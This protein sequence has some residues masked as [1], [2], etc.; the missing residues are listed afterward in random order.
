[1]IPRIQEE[2]L[3]HAISSSKII[4]VS[5]AY[6]VGKKTLIEKCCD[7]VGLHIHWMNSRLKNNTNS[8]S[9]GSINNREEGVIALRDAEF[10]PNLQEIVDS[11]LNEEIDKKII[12]SCSYTPNLSEE[13]LEAMHDSR[14]AFKIYPTTFVEASQHYGITNIDRLL[15]DRLIFGSYTQVL[16][17]RENA[18]NILLELVLKVFKTNLSKGTRINKEK[19]LMTLLRKLAFSIGEIITFHD[20]GQSVGLDNETVERYIEMLVDADIIIKLKSYSTDKRYELKKTHCIYFVDNGIRNALIQ[21]FNHP[22]YRNDMPQLWK[23]FLIAEKFKWSKLH[24]MNVSY[25][26]WRTHTKQQID[27]IE[28]KEDGKKYAYKMDWEKRNKVK[29][30]PYFISN[31]PEIKSSVINKNTYWSFLSKK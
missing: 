17:N 10:L 6:G 1:M 14:L 16:E 12:L 8:I 25:M 22:D 24:R 11:A 20:L 15:E 9:I 7:Q 21:N 30:P 19:E 13:L 18:E 23:N 26:F 29:L 3:I 31:Y 5:G 28:Q 4:L 2:E 27:F